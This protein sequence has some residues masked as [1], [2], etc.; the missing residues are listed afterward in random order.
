MAKI[1]GIPMIGHVYYRSQMCKSLSY[2]C[3]A[4]CN[5]EIKEYIESIGGVAIMTSNKHER[6]SDR[7]AEALVKMEKLT[8]RK[9]DIAVMIQGD[10][11]M[12]I[13][14]MI[15]QV[16]Q[17]LRKDP[18][19]LIS[20]L[21]GKIASQKEF[22]DPNVVKAV[23]DTK[24]FALYFSREPIPSAKK[25]KGDYKKYK[26][27]AIIPFRRDFLIKFNRLTPTPLEIVESVDMMRVLEHGYKVKMVPSVFDT[28]SVDT[29]SDLQAVEKIMSRDKICALYKK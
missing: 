24:S 20:N 8:G 19:I 4:T 9:A 28:Y 6:A 14:Q 12:L 3:V 5:V 15:D 7:A 25:H 17:P 2:V 27:I 23:V 29:P 26:Q 13:P 10:E 22:E 16:V 1:C 21:L 18:S 11:P